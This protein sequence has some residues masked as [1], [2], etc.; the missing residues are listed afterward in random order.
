MLILG[1]T[2]ADEFKLYV[3]ESTPI[4][5]LGTYHFG[6]GEGEW[7]LTIKTDGKKVLASYSYT[8]YDAKKDRWLPNVNI[9]IKNVKITGFIF[10]AD[11]FLGTFMLEKETGRKSLVLVK[12]RDITQATVGLELLK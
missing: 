1:T 11:G 10:Q 6:E 2:P 12:G 7:S 4:N 9:P 5:Y 8:P 3:D